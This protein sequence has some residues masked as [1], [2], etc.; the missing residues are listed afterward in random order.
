MANTQ[1]NVKDLVKSTKELAEKSG[2]EEFQNELR[3]L[4][5]KHNGPQRVESIMKA[6]GMVG[7]I[8]KALKDAG[9]PEG[10]IAGYKLDK[11]VLECLSDLAKSC[12]GV[13]N[14]YMLTAVEKDPETFGKFMKEFTDLNTA[15]AKKLR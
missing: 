3:A 2:S 10:K 1:G 6:S 13:D 5:E 9:A 14:S 11:L 12:G 4:L 15:I 8:R 7:M